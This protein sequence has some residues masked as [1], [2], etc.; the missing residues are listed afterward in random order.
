VEE[1]LGVFEVDHCEGGGGRVLGDWWDG[2]W[3]DGGLWRWW[4][5]RIRICATFTFSSYL[6][7]PSYNGILLL[8]FTADSLAFYTVN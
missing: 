8:A 4:E 6:I 1:G 2:W 3:E 5:M 7:T